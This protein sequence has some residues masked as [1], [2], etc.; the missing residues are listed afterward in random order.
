MGGC[1]AWSACSPAVQELLRTGS[2]RSGL[3]WPGTLLSCQWGIHCLLEAKPGPWRGRWLIETSFQMIRGV[4][5]RGGEPPAPRCMQVGTKR[6]LV[7][8]TMMGR[9]WGPLE[10]LRGPEVLCPHFLKPFALPEGVMLARLPA[11]TESWEAGSGRGLQSAVPAQTVA[12]GAPGRRLH[13]RA[14][15]GTALQQESYVNVGSGAQLSGS[16]SCG[17][18]DG[19]QIEEVSM[20]LSQ[21]QE[22]GASRPDTPS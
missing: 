6:P 10:D 18:R 20:G 7:R 3:T 14:V 2:D 17:R 1:W 19:T 16:S 12:A 5:L 22:G 13:G 15:H 8:D 21:G 4:T 9:G 11:T